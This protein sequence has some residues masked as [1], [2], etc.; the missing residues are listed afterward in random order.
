MEEVVGGRGEEEERGKTVGRWWRRVVK[1]R[2]EGDER[3]ERRRLM[4]GVGK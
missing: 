1:G 2:G 3:A 4:E